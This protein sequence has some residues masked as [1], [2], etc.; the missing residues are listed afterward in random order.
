MNI[1]SNISSRRGTEQ[2]L[3]QE[4]L[5]NPQSIFSLWLDQL[6]VTNTNKSRRIK[7]NKTAKLEE[8]DRESM[9]SV[10]NN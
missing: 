2:K 4:H 10:A 6:L 7:A 8:Q 5:L 3:C 1:D 9:K